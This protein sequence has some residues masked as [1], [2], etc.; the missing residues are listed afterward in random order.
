MNEKYKQYTV[1]ILHVT[2]LKYIGNLNNIE[3]I[4]IKITLKHDPFDIQRKCECYHDE[5]YAEPTSLTSSIV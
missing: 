2:M 5:E 4:F 1:N 3:Q